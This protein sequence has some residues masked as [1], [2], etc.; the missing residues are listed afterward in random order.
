[1][2]IILRLFWMDQATSAALAL[3]DTDLRIAQ[4][5]LDLI[6]NS[7]CL[8]IDMLILEGWMERVRQEKNRGVESG[9][10][11]KV[12][13]LIPLQRY[14]NNRFLALLH[15]ARD[16]WYEDREE[17]ELYDFDPPPYWCCA[18]QEDEEDRG[19]ACIS[20]GEKGREECAFAHGSLSKRLN[21]C[22]AAGCEGSGE[23]ESPL[24][25]FHSDYLPPTTAGYGCDLSVL[26]KYEGEGHEAT[27]KEYEALEALVQ[28]RDE[29]IESM[30][31]LRE[32][33]EF[34]NRYLGQTPVDLSGFQGGL[35][36]S[37]EHRS[38]SGCIGDEEDWPEGAVAWEL[39][40]PFSL[41][42]NHT[43]L[44]PKLYEIWRNWGKSRLLPDYLK[45]S[46]E[47]EG[48]SER[49][50]IVEEYEQSVFGWFYLTGR[51]S[52][53]RYFRN[54]AVA[55]EGKESMM[56][57]KVLDTPLRIFDELRTL[58][59][60]VKSFVES[61]EEPNS[62][63]RGFVRNFAF[64]LRHSCIFRPCNDQLNRIL[65]IVF[66]DSC[67]PYASGLYLTDSNVDETCRNGAR[68]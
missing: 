2:D 51:N 63:I 44:M 32:I 30:G 68:L 60:E 3:V 37:I 54:N 1:M 6:E 23:D 36:S 22:I 48:N 20:V 49:Q 24:C 14:L 56:I 40:G 31:A 64:F 38:V 29:F 7:P 66:E 61:V 17:G 42:R 41:K 15:G 8:H 43:S 9:N 67:F 50:K 16:P 34:L 19:S 25:P 59:G 26:R 57:A 12:F 11:R 18:G 27:R 45:T 55:Q 65:S 21:V 47:L 33:T 5:E 28:S 52:A 58:R 10:V 13:R 62:G 53:R 39:R 4:Q 46:D 35:S